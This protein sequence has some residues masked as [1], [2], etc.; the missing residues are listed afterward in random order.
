MIRCLVM[1]HGNIG[2]ELVRVAVPRIQAIDAFAEIVRESPVPV[3][4]DVHFHHEVAVAAVRAGAHKLRINPGNIG[5]D[6]I[7]QRNGVGETEIDALSGQW[8]Y[9]VCRVTQ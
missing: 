8:M 6:D 9:C 4:A 2:A 5:G 7:A 1:T 3:I